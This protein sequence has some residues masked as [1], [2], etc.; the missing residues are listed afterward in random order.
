V[1]QCS[2][3]RG[4]VLSAPSNTNTRRRAGRQAVWVRPPLPRPP[5]PKYCCC[6]RIRSPQTCSAF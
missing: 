6:H 4:T 3:C 2:S 5:C 1:S